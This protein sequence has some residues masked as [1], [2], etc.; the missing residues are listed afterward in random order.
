MFDDS[1]LIISY[2][3]GALRK[4]LPNYLQQNIFDKLRFLDF[5]SKQVQI[6]DLFNLN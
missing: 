4:E 5:K 6:E 1:L 3:Q 2:V